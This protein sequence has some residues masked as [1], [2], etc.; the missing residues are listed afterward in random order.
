MMMSSY[1][2]GN[3]EL[4]AMIVN[5]ARKKISTNVLKEFYNSPQG[6]ETDRM[7]LSKTPRTRLGE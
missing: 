6:T 3:R 5:N 7:N 2:E 4:S 1:F